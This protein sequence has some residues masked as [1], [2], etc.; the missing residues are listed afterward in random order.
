M[1]QDKPTL[2]PV[3]PHVLALLGVA[4]GAV[5]LVIAAACGAGNR[6]P[7]VVQCQLDALEVLPEDIGHV[8]VYDAIDIYN[9]VHDCRRAH[10]DA[11]QP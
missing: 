5:P 4:L 7:P 11:G 10:P 2:R 6:L 1:S 8:T 9:R 3:R